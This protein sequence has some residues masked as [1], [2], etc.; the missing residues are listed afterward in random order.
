[1][2]TEYDQAQGIDRV[3]GCLFFSQRNSCI[4][5]FELLYLREGWQTSGKINVHA[6]MNAIWSNF[7]EYAVAHN[8]GEQSGANDLL[9][10][11]L[12]AAGG[13]EDVG[14]SGS[15]KTVISLSP[16]MGTTFFCW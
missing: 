15:S 9:G 3:M 2:A 14:W 8:L 13:N 5:L 16:Q 11:I 10:L 7:H 12:N 4:P 1:M 6:R